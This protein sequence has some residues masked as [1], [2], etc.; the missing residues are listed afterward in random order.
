MNKSNLVLWLIGPNTQLAVIAVYVYNT[1]YKAIRREMRNG[2]VKKQ[3][4][5]R[6]QRWEGAALSGNSAPAL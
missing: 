1:D 2:F 3:I 6:G 5:R 4:A